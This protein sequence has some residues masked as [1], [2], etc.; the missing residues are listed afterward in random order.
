MAI[1]PLQLDSLL[2]NISIFSK[3]RLTIV[4]GGKVSENLIEQL[5][6]IPFECFETYGMT[7][8]VSHIAV[9]NLKNQT[10]NNPYICLK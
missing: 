7:E 1:T 9:R 4:G 10:E 2:K 5:Q 8:T 6:N 3:I